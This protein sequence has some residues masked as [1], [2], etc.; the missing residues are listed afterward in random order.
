MASSV[1]ATIAQI[2]VLGMEKTGVGARLLS[3]ASSRA[4]ASAVQ[5]MNGEAIPDTAKLIAGTKPGN[6]D[7][8]ITRPP[9]TPDFQIVVFKRCCPL[10]DKRFPFFGGENLYP[11]GLGY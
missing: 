11:R 2:R 7:T 9:K 3:P 10:F 8:Q 4:A 1:A 5:A 6:I